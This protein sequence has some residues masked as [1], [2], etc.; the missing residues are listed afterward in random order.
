MGHW[1]N[2]ASAAPALSLNL[3]RVANVPEHPLPSIRLMPYA[4][5]AKALDLASTQLDSPKPSPEKRA[6]RRAVCV[7]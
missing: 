2:A 5:V 7:R 1:G 6:L 3:Q 4:H